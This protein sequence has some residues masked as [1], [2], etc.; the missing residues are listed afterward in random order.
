MRTPWRPVQTS[1]NAIDKLYYQA[2]MSKSAVIGN[3]SFETQT[4]ECGEGS[5]WVMNT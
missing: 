1:T 2:K 5:D 3:L 4:P